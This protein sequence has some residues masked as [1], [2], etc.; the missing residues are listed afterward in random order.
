MRQF[1][2]NQL[3]KLYFR[4]IP[5]SH[6]SMSSTVAS[7]TPELE[8]HRVPCLKD[9]YAWLL[10]EP[11]SKLT[12]VVDPSESSPVITAL[13]QNGY[14]LDYVLN[15]H[16]HWDHTGGNL[17]LKK[18]YNCTVVGAVAD[19][20]RIPGIDIEL[21]E[22]DQ[23]KFGNLNMSVFETP[24]HTSGHISLYFPEASSV[25]TGDTLFMMGCGRLFEGTADQMWMSLSKLKR[26]PSDTKVFCGHEYTQANA[27]FAVAHDPS[28]AAINE[29]KNTIDD[30]RQKGEPTVPGTMEQELAT[31]PFLLVDNAQQF[32]AVRKAKDNF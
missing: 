5:T 9:N 21:K 11:I 29:R 19:R 6:L 22:G 14:G 18:K 28:N 7:S 10:H 13:E 32:A 1:I 8:V 3:L 27:R 24:G 2:E 25:F 12:A 31:N 30:M 20:H 23:W 17:E 4:F 16:H 26:L 15:T